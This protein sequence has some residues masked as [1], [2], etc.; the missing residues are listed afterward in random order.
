MD[1][2]P[3][4]RD[5]ESGQRQRGELEEVARRERRPHLV[6]VL[7]PHD[8]LVGE[9]RAHPLR[10]LRHDLEPHHRSEAARPQILLHRLEQI[11][12]LFLVFGDVG[13]PGDPE[14]IGLEK[15][16]A[17]EEALQ[18]LGDHHLERHET[19]RHPATGPSAAGSAA[20]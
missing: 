16:H 15:L 1:L 5:L 4:L 14:G 2:R 9:Q 18:E 11:L 13:R 17:R 7:R 8:Q 6:D 12:R 10:H 19:Q 3:P 20:P